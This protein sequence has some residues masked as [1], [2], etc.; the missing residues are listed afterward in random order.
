MA[1]RKQS[2]NTSN[3]SYSQDPVLRVS[4]GL[5]TP[6]GTP[7]LRTGEDTWSRPRVVSV[8]EYAVGHQQTRTTGRIRGDA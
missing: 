2:R 3:P 4:E 8:E 1:N 5:A 6:G 7:A